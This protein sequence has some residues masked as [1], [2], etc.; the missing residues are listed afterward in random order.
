MGASLLLRAFVRN[1][2]MRND[3]PEIYGWRVFVIVASA[4]FGGMIF[5]WETG[6]IG[7]ILALDPFAKKFNYFSLSKTAK[8]NQQQNIVSILQAGCFTACL[9][10]WWPADR[11]GRR[12]S[13]M[14]AGI[15]T[16]I[17]VVFQACSAIEGQLPL[18]YVG[19]FI[20]GLGV[21]SASAL[22][23]MYIAEC[24]PRAI[25]GALIGMRYQTIITMIQPCY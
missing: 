8:S 6:A 3:P 4:C 16:T 25:R 1:D 11:F 22:T 7:G 19:R 20:T 9:I 14:G 24:A 13:L 10:T 5:G 15:V 21:G 12:I 2:A 18:M 17:G 23:P